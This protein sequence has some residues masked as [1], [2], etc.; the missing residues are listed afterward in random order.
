MKQV[1]EEHHMKEVGA[2]HIG[3]VNG[4]YYKD[5]KAHKLGK[6]AIG[7]FGA[8][9]VKG[10][11]SHSAMDKAVEG[12]TPDAYEIN[13]KALNQGTWN[14]PKEK[15]PANIKPLS[16]NEASAVKNKTLNVGSMKTIDGVTYFLNTN[17]RWQKVEGGNPELSQKVTDIKEISAGVKAIRE[18]MQT[19]NPVDDLQSHTRQLIQDYIDKHGSHPEDDKDIKKL[20]NKNSKVSDIHEALSTKIDSDIVTKQ[21]IFHK[22]IELKDGHSPAIQ[23]LREINKRMKGADEETIK[24]YFPNKVDDILKEMHSHKDIFLDEK[25]NFQLR[26]HYLTGNA[27]DKM[28][29]LQKSINS[30][31][32]LKKKSKLQQSHDEVKKAIGWKSIEESSFKAY[33]KWV[34]ESIVQSWIKKETLGESRSSGWGGRSYETFSNPEFI[35]GQWQVEG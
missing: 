33:N 3:W 20:I 7:N 18:A 16:K 22:E 30:E 31:K 4:T 26:E 8:S 29:A 27:Y 5:N 13:H 9:I 10:D 2:F 11:L 12:F 21:N 32:D 17:H 23:A 25:G 35:D 6:D 14:A 24:S 15:T 28:D 34:P 19:E 1:Y